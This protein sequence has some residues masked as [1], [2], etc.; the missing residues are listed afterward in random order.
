[1]AKYDKDGNLIEEEVDDGGLEEM[2]DDY[3]PQKEEQPADEGAG[4]DETGEEAGEVEEEEGEETPGTDEGGGEKETPSEEEGEETPPKDTSEEKVVLTTE[5]YNNLLGQ[6]NALAKGQPMEAPVKE[7]VKEGEEVEEKK[8][9]PKK[10]EPFKPTEVYIEDDDKMDEIFRD[11]DKLNE[12][13]VKVRNEG[14]RLGQEQVLMSIPDVVAKV[15]T[16]Q[17]ELNEAVRDFYKA[18]EDLRPHKEFVGFV[19]NELASKFPEKSR[20]ELFK[21][22]GVEV[23]KRLGLEKLAKRKEVERKRRNPAFGTKKG[24]SRQAPAA[25]LNELEKEIDDL[26]PEW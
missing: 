9:A 23:R 20:D 14:S 22:V 6:I 13:L 24:Q 16:M 8:E 4:E 12:L 18:N 2:V 15:A 17:I 21:D 3:I 26:I 7:E 11:R 10:F 19:A 5:E 25:D 1:M